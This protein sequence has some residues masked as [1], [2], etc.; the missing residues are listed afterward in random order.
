MLQLVDIEPSLS[1]K[2]LKEPEKTAPKPYVTRVIKDDGTLT[3]K[4]FVP[5]ESDLKILQGIV[6][7]TSPGSTLADK[8]RVVSE[9]EDRDI[10]LAG[11]T[12]AIRQLSKLEK[13][14]AKL[15]GTTIFI[16]GMVKADDNFAAIQQRLTEELPKGL[17]LDVSGIKPP[18]AKPFVW[19][20]QFKA[21]RLNMGGH[22]PS[23]GEQA[24]L[25]SH[26]KT[27]FQENAVD[28]AMGS[29]GG[30]PSEWINA[31]KLCVEMLVLLQQGSATLQD[32]NIKLDGV[33]AGSATE[34]LLKS[35]ANRFPK[36]FRLELNVSQLI[37]RVPAAHS[38]SQHPEE[39][40]FVTQTTSHILKP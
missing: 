27:V 40:N 34:E 30:A 38:P 17:T 7:A 16:D 2:T 28:D 32:R 11:M 5:S 25:L 23:D 31:A 9:V 12:Y 37:L 3:I 18:A 35:Y 39:I 22:V 10:W 19:F 15:L 4:D 21:G 1:L 6:A 26:A 24:Q 33:V 13:G 29:A 36:G 8:T 20:A 14:R